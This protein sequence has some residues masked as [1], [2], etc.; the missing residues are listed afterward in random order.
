MSASLS[1]SFTLV[2]SADGTRVNERLKEALITKNGKRVYRV[3]DGIPVM[4]EDESITTE[5]IENF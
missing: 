5:Q 3:E 2:P 1:R 4:L